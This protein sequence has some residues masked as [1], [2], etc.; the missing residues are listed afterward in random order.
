[1]AEGRNVAQYL[2]RDPL[3]GVSA[4]YTVEQRTDRWRDGEVVRCLPEDRISAS[5]N[6]RTIRRSDDVDGHL[7][8]SHAKAANGAWWPDTSPNCLVIGVEVAG[9]AKDGPTEARQRSMVALWT[10]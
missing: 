3:W 1:M 8:A 9:F 5:I 2:A 10:N 4:H 6:P 7:G